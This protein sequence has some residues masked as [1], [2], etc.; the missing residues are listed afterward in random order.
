[1]S[2]NPSDAAISPSPPLWRACDSLRRSQCKFTFTCKN[3]KCK[4]SEP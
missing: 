1:M 2:P 3:F 4:S